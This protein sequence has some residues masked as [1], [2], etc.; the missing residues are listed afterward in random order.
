MELDCRSCKYHVT[1]DGGYSN[2]TVTEQYVSCLKGKFKG[3]EDSYG[4]EEKKFYKQFDECP[5]FKNGYGPSF[6]VDGEVTIEDYKEDQEI[7]DLLKENG[8]DNK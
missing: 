7:Y 8:F 3:V 4:W 5:H 2:W 1:Q 6:D